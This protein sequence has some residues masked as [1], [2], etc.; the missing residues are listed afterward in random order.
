MNLVS[1]IVENSKP[2]DVINEIDSITFKKDYINK[3]KPLLIK[4]FAKNW[5]A[6]RKWSLDFFLNFEEDKDILLLDNNYI[7][8]SH[9]F[10]KGSFKD[11]ILKLKEAE[12]NNGTVKDYLTT[13]NIF[14]YFPELK[15]DLDFSFY[16]KHTKLND[17]S[18]WI[19]PS[20]TI[21]DFHADTANNVYAQIKGRKMFIICSPEFNKNMYPSNKHIYGAIACSVNINNFDHTRFPNFKNTVFNTI[22]LEPGDVLFIPKKWWHYVQALDSSISVSNFGY[23]KKEMYTL[24]LKERIFQSLHKR[25]YYKRNNCFCCE[26]KK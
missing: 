17:V 18:A 25:G 24:I 4:G 1:E 6:T 11:Y 16:E 8:D 12:K 15:E 13:L 2:I 5:G 21:S 3:Q 9:G 23:T 10:K 26:E 20:G 19:G 14:H 22:I 7:Q